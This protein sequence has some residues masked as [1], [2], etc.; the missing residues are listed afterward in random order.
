MPTTQQLSKLGDPCQLENPG[1]INGN[2]TIDQRNARMQTNPC[3]LGFKRKLGKI[4]FNLIS[5]KSDRFW[6]SEM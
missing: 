6:T 2:N 3:S 5:P 1:S 4:S